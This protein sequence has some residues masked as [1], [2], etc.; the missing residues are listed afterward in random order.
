M[1][2]TTSPATP[3]SRRPGSEQPWRQ[4]LEGS[5]HG[6]QAS[7]RACRVAWPRSWQGPDHGEQ[8]GARIQPWRFARS[9][10]YL[11][12]SKLLHEIH[13][14][15]NIKM[16]S[17][18]EVCCRLFSWPPAPAW[19]WASLSRPGSPGPAQR[20]QVLWTWGGGGPRPAQRA[21]WQS[22]D[23][24][25]SGSNWLG[26]SWCWGTWE[27]LSPLGQ[28]RPAE[29][30]QRG[31]RSWEDSTAEDPSLPGVLRAP[32]PPQANATR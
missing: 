2:H 19:P 21:G 1:C 7:G 14:E 24:P 6:V 32:P 12:H 27:G 17:T 31:Q 10:H 4:G 11:K 18:D 3:L 5:A 29:G 16:Q 20:Q 13:D 22:P 23:A 9:V 8:G 15:Q 26:T 25:S 28:R 30:G